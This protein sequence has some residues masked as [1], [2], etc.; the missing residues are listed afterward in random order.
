MNQ[1]KEILRAIAFLQGARE[2][3]GQASRDIDSSATLNSPETQD[4]AKGAIFFLGR[5][6]GYLLGLQ[7]TYRANLT[8]KTRLEPPPLGEV[9][10][11]EESAF[12][13]ILVRDLRE[14]AKAEWDVLVESAEAATEEQRKRLDGAKMAH[15]KWEEW[16]DRQELRLTS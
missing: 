3:L 14:E 2:W 12:L 10:T 11:A 6:S 5:T 8:T 7:D 16:I 1:D 13:L 15:R 9:V 4:K